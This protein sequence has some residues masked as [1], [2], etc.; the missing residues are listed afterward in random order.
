MPD[1]ELT[2]KQ[3]ARVAGSAAA[4]EYVVVRRE[5]IFLALLY[6]QGG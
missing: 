2:T 5:G 1:I 3:A 6:I 4:P